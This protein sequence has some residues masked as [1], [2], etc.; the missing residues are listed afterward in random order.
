MLNKDL[1][2][3]EKKIFKI[4]LQNDFMTKKC[5]RFTHNLFRYNS[6]FKSTNKTLTILQ[7]RKLNN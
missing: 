7:Q 4:K 1:F 5:F 3:N 6:F 2:K